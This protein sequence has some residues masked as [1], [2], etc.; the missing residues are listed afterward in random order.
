MHLDSRSHGGLV[1]AYEATVFG[2]VG[3]DAVIKAC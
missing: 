1:D 2:C 3:P